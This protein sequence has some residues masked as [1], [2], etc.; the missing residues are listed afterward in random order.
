MSKILLVAEQDAGALRKSTFQSLSF[1]QQLA[2]RTGA[3]YDIALVGQGVSGL[4]DGDLT[5]EA[6]VT[7]DITGA[8]ADSINYAIE[9]L[10]EL[11]TTINETGIRIDGAARQTRRAQGTVSAAVGR[12][13]GRSL[14]H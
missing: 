11:V 3:S 12:S 9:A 1:V 5:V 8:I 10:R 7:E 6:T 2:A 14:R 4:A 13:W